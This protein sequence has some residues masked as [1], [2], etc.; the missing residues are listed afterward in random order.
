[1][2][3]R[4]HSSFRGLYDV[5]AEMARMREHITHA[6]SAQDPSTGRRVW[7]PATDIFVDGDDFVIRCELAGVPKSDVNV[8][9]A[10]GQLWISGERKDAPDADDDS[11]YVRERRYGPFRRT[12]ALPETA[13]VDRITATVED[14]L[15][16]IVVKGCAVADDHEQIE[17]AGAEST[18]IRLDVAGDG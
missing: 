8:S 9:L 16:E 17:I 5:F 6:D 1:M 2:A 11:F 15:L 10:G 18:E 4:Q 14:G 3:D 13:A 7:V 12:I